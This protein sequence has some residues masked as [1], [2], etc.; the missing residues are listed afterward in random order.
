MTPLQVRILRALDTPLTTGQIGT[1]VG[2]TGLDMLAALHGIGVEGW[3]T[4]ET[5]GRHLL[6]HRTPAG[7]E[8][9]A[10]IAGEEPA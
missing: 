7:T 4:G 10:A 5:V 6:W 8:A 3:A 9:L 1:A 2:V